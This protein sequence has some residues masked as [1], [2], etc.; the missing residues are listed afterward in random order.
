MPLERSLRYFNLFIRHNFISMRIMESLIERLQIISAIEGHSSH[1]SRWI[2]TVILESPIEYII[3]IV[4]KMILLAKE[5]RSI[6]NYQLMVIAVL[7]LRGQVMSRLK[8]VF[9]K[10]TTK[11]NKIYQELQEL[12]SSDN[13]F[14]N[15]RNALSQSKPPYIPYMYVYAILIIIYHL[16]SL[17][18]CIYIYM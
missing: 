4:G 12:I 14:K 7:S 16:Y 5:L 11:I 8:L 18:V 17:H 9:Q 13:E 3:P 10:Q 6:N 15:I 1:F 2:L